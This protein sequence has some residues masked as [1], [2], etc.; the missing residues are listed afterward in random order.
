[1]RK[2]AQNSAHPRSLCL[3]GTINK[4][5]ECVQ[6]TWG[7]VKCFGLSEREGHEMVVPGGTDRFF[8]C[9]SMDSRFD[10]VLTAGP[11]R[12]RTSICQCIQVPYRRDCTHSEPPAV[13]PPIDLRHRRKRKKKKSLGRPAIAQA[14]YED[15]A[16]RPLN[17][18]SR[19]RVPPKGATVPVPSIP[20]LVRWTFFQRTPKFHARRL[21]HQNGVIG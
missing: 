11:M 17:T 18:M 19:R 9:G 7:T 20:Q 12:W 13:V 2:I 1:M 14:T 21:F 15:A 4:D 16:S 3:G 5:L 10:M 6:Y 8:C